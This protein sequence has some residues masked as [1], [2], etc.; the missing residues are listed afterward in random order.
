MSQA[1]V[2][3]P[4]NA[5]HLRQGILAGTLLIRYPSGFADRGYV[6]CC[7]CGLHSIAVPPAHLLNET[8]PGTVPGET[9]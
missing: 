9:L 8:A 6:P 1:E 5:L 7:S 3:L 2:D 4:D